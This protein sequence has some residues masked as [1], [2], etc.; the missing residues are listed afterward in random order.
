MSD[1]ISNVR[2]TPSTQPVRRVRR[3]SKDEKS[4]EQEAERKKPGPAIED[5][6][7]TEG[8][9]DEDKPLLDEYA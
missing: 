8:A 4:G 1:S 2:N 9:P 5:G 7:S 6:E 3:P